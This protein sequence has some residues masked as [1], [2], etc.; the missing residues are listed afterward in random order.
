V[1]STFNLY[2]PDIV[3]H[4]AAYKHVPLVEANIADGIV[5]NIVGTKNIIDS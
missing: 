5:N 2:K 1:A 4:V 3:I